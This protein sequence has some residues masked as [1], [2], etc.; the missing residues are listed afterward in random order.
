LLSSHEV[1]KA[2]GIRFIGVLDFFAYH[3][4]ASPCFWATVLPYDAS[5]R[6]TAAQSLRLGIMSAGCILVRSRGIAMGTGIVTF[7]WPV[8]KV[9]QH[10]EEKRMENP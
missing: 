2:V 8:A 1:L 3:R 9:L 4:P 7:V 5:P 10:G 6:I